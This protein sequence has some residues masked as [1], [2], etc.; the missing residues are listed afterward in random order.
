MCLSVF[1]GEYKKT[2]G[3]TRRIDA[4]PVAVFVDIAGGMGLAVLCPCMWL[5]AVVAGFVYA[6]L[7][8]GAD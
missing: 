5:L 1:C 6:S 8:L 4:V 2:V 7:L 3:S